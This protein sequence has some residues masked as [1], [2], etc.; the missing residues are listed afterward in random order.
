MTVE[1]LAV[2]LAVCSVAWSAVLM[3]V[4]KAAPTVVKGMMWA[5]IAKCREDRY[6][7]CVCLSEC[8]REKSK[9]RKQTN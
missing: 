8:Q 3:A 1:N 6:I 2:Y 5:V 9:Q 4:V 7:N